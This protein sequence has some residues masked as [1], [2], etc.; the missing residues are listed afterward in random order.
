M[1]LQAVLP[2]AAFGIVACATVGGMRNIP[3]D[4]GTER[5]FAADLNAAVLA[6]RNAIAASA[7]AIV[8]FEQVGETTWIV[9]ATGLGHETT[10]DELVRVVCEALRPGEVAIRVVTKRRGP[11]HTMTQGDWSE[12]LLTQI[13]LELGDGS[14]EH[15]P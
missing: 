4:E 14:A 12:T 3:L 6:V 11:L 9:I 5:R 8:E 2:T 1:R 7:L 10:H 13:A 15:D